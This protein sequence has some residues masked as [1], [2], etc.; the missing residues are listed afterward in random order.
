LYH[1]LPAVYFAPDFYGWAYYGWASPVYYPWGWA[2]F[3][4]Y[5][6][7]GPYF[8][9]APFYSGASLWLTDYVLGEILANAYQMQQ[10]DSNAPPDE[11]AGALNPFPGPGAAD[12]GTAYAQADSPITPELKQAIAD[13]VQQQLSYESAAAGQPDQA[14]TLSGLPQA[15]QPG[16]DFVVSTPLDVTTASERTC[17]LEAGNVLRLDAT[18]VD[19]NP[20]PRLTVVASRV[21][22]CPAGAQVTLP[23]DQ[24]EEMENGFRAELDNGLQTLFKKQ[25]QNGLP[26]APQSAIV[27]PR[28][29]GLTAFD[30]PDL[31]ARLQDELKQ[32]SE[33]ETQANRMAFD[34]SIPPI[35]YFA[36]GA[37][38]SALAASA[39]LW[40]R[41]R[42]NPHT[43]GLPLPAPQ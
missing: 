23:L 25:G 35:W 43:A 20:V 13:E 33:V 9:V 19:D 31:D 38:L 1:Y 28:P 12:G 18:P 8:A 22:D 2:G 7:Y 29:S 16:H 21:S 32:A 10:G 34:G 17:N 42:R 40:L 27:P 30:Q 5:R 6:Y 26:A 36:T 15:M 41:R 14:P 24:L 4:W 11:S 39:M 37:T 3:P